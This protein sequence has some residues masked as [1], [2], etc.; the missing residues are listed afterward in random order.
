MKKFF[1]FILAIIFIV[2]VFSVIVQAASV[3]T[4]HTIRTNTMFIISETGLAD[5]YTSYYARENVMTEATITIT[6]KKRTL[7][8]FWN[9]VTTHTLYSTEYDYNNSFEY[10][11]SEKGT[12]KCEVEY[13]IS[14]TAGEADVLPFEDTVTY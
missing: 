14:G 10:Q 3:Y 12:Y 6:I 7:L 11:L 4:N 5:V 2:S 13:V 9:E 8:F 1:T